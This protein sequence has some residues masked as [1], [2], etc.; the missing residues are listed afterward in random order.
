[1][2]PDNDNILNQARHAGF[3]NSPDERV[4][5]IFVPSYL[6]GDDGIFNLPYYD[7][8]IDSIFSIFPSYYEPWGY[9]PHE[10]WLSRPHYHH[11]TCRFRCMGTEAGRQKGMD[12]GIE[13]IHR[14]P[15][16]PC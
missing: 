2:D 3:C 4:K 8:L 9:T 13:V 14:E 1:M 16:R 12:D 7:L 10:A 15:T 6:N 5:I 11:F